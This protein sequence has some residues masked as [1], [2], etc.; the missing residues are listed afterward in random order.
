MRELH[1]SKRA[2]IC[3]CTLGLFLNYALTGFKKDLTDK[4]T[5][6]KTLCFLTARR[7]ATGAAAEQS[8]HL[9]DN[10]SGR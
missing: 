8:A 6:E 2:K 3:E 10:D 7:A 5:K 4:M 9:S 1:L